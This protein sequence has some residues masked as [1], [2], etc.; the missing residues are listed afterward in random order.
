MVTKRSTGKSARPK[1]ATKA[2][3]RKPLG[4]IIAEIGKQIS[5]EDKAD[6][7]RDGAANHDHYIYGTPKQY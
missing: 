5:D 7:P 2:K 1:R 3:P 6:M 4:Q